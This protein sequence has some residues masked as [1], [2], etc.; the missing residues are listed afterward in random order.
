MNVT[1]SKPAL[2][3]LA[4][5]ILLILAF[6]SLCFYA[7][8]EAVTT[9]TPKDEFRIPELNGSINF[10]L[11]GSYSSAILENSTWAFNDLSL[12]NSQPLGN[13]KISVENSNI[14]VWSFR[15]HLIFARSAQI[16][17]N[18]QG[19]GNQTINLGI[20]ST[21]PTHPSEWTVTVPSATVPRTVFLAEGDHWNLLPDNSV[22]VYGLT[23]NVT[24]THYGFNIPTTSNLPFYQQHSI[25]ITTAVLLLVILAVALVIHFKV[26]S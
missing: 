7:S 14:T 5:A 24:V 1:T 22:V 15:T 6:P 4:A 3:G 8:A 2:I 13:L 10:Y 19:I 11:N 9:F 20:N 23:G 21:Q 17:Y 25:I 18:V 26:R 16:R 12:N